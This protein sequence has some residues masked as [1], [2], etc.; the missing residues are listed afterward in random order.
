MHGHQNVFSLILTQGDSKRLEQARSWEDKN[1]G[2]RL[3]FNGV[4]RQQREERRVGER[5]RE[6]ETFILSLQQRRRRRRRQWQS[7]EP[8]FTQREDTLFVVAHSQS[9]GATKSRKTRSKKQTLSPPAHSS[10]QRIII[11]IR[12]PL[13]LFLILFL[14][15]QMCHPFYH[16]KLDMNFLLLL[17]L[18]RM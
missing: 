7:I 4:R 2:L 15:R 3:R 18:L 1:W 10:C 17:L 12:L 14:F 9:E 5:E 8:A 16:P 13:S 11:Y 6:R